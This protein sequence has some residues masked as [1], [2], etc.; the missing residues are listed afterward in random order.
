[1]L[2]IMHKVKLLLQCPQQVLYQLVSPRCG[3]FDLLSG[4]YSSKNTP[5][6]P[7]DAELIAEAVFLY[8][9]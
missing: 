2:F 1:M 9:L 8:V 6:G 5:N 7:L 3:S 4:S